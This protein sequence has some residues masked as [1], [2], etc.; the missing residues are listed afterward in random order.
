MDYKINVLEAK[1]LL[2]S[3]DISPRAK[4]RF[5]ENFTFREA[6]KD[7]KS[8]NMIFLGGFLKSLAN[9]GK[10]EKPLDTYLANMEA[11]IS[12][13]K[14]IA[15]T[16]PLNVEGVNGDVERQ[17]VVTKLQKYE[18]Q[19]KQAVSKYKQAKAAY[20]KL[21][22]VE[23]E[24][25]KAAEQEAIQ[26]NKNA[27][28]E[29]LVS[30]GV[31]LEETSIDNAENFVKTLSPL[32]DVTAHPENEDIAETIKSA[33]ED[34]QGVLNELNNGVIAVGSDVFNVESFKG[35]QV[36]A[37]ISDPYVVTSVRKL[38]EKLKADL[39]GNDY[40]DKIIDSI[41]AKF[42][43]V[44]EATETPE[45]EQQEEGTEESQEAPAEESENGAEG[46]AE[47]EAKDETAEATEEQ[48]QEE[49][50]EE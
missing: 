20:D 25:S 12:G 14:E 21:A 13:M 16:R 26:M 1:E 5:I 37:N 29:L 48:P 33:V 24:K 11:A 9:F 3:L 32:S 27:V 22:A 41:L 40:S 46:E 47:S 39:A 36:A 49:T 38:L 50:I 30:V 7:Q 10:H 35:D 23:Q 4:K 43:G 17:K 34:I 45:G 8:K 31:N 15:E 2:E 19:L 44:P 28:D 42:N 6:V 18:A